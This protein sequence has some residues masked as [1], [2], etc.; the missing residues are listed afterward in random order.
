MLADWG[1]ELVRGDVTDAA[2][3]ASAVA[4]CD[5]VV[6]LVA[7]VKGSDQ[8][9]ERIMKQG[10]RSLVAAAKSAGV[11]RFVHMSALGTGESS[12]DLTPYF[13]AKWDQ[14]QA[15]KESGLEYVILRPSFVFG[16]EGG[17][18]KIFMRLVRLAGAPILSRHAEVAAGLGGRRRRVLRQGGDRAGGREPDVRSRRRRRRLTR[19]GLPRSSGGRSESGDRRSTF[20]SGSRRPAAV[21]QVRGPPLTRDTL[22]MLEFEDNVGDAGPAIET[23]GI[24]PIGLEEMLRRAADY[25]A[26]IDALRR[27]RDV[28]LVRRRPNDRARRAG[29][30]RRVRRPPRPPGRAPGSS[31]SR[32]STSSGGGRDSVNAV[33]AGT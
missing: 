18:L 28:A 4:G 10:T 1:C 17:A 22:T 14:E 23:F 21:G 33:E 5:A 15:V 29:G 20:R 3:L 27:G 24:T 6:H 32:A 30:G 26:G 9:F 16:P 31:S 8:A 19:E 2:S 25:S 12:K 13:S 11:R 7:I